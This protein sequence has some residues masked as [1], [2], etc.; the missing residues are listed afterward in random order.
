[1]G[2]ELRAKHDNASGRQADRC[3]VALHIPQWYYLSPAPWAWSCEPNMTMPAG[4]RLTAVQLALNILVY[5]SMVLPESRP[6]GVELRAKHD[7]AS[8]GQADRCTVSPQYSAVVLPESSP[9][10]VEL[11]AKHD[12]ASGGQADRC[13][14]SPQYSSVGTT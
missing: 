11:R 3:T 4:G 10:G 7:N 6:V 14:V 13:T 9:V 1:M 5:S 12:N 2:V 8:G